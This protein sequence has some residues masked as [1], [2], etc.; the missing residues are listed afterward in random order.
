MFLI[1]FIYCAMCLSGQIGP[2]V[3]FTKLIDVSL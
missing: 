2:K 1:N 3:R